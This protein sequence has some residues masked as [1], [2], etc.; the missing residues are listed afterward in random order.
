MRFH[1]YFSINRMLKIVGKA[2]WRQVII[3]KV[4]AKSYDDLKP[5]PFGVNTFFQNPLESSH[6]L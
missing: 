4:N 3:V 2:N 6:D 5:S 1:N